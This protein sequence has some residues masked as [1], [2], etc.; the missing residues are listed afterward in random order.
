M[1]SI[2]DSPFS[3]LLPLADM[4]TTLAESALAASSNEM[5]VRVLSS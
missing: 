4:L 2:S 1:V 3:M 5:R